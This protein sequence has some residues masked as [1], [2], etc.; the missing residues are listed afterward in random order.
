M[1][2]PWLLQT[3]KTEDETFKFVQ[4]QLFLL[5]CWTGSEKNR[6]F[7]YFRGVINIFWNSLSVVGQYAYAYVNRKKLILVL[8][9]M[10]PATTMI[11]TSFKLFIL[12]WRTDTLNGIFEEIKEAFRKGEVLTFVNETVLCF[13]F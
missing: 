2:R 1:K 10:C 5:G 7:T 13:F 12:L 9:C 11:V 8:D 3:P 6:T 4:F